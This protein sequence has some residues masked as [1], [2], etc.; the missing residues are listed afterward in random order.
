MRL[1][2][3]S[4][5][6]LAALLALAALAAAPAGAAAPIK[7]STIQLKG[8]HGYS[9]EL[10]EGISGDF[11][12]ETGIYAE[13]GAIGASYEVLGDLEPGIHASFGDLGRADLSFQRR[14]RVVVRPERGCRI[15]FETGIFRGRFSFRGENGYTRVSAT[16]PRGEVIRL[17]NGFCG[18]GAF[19]NGEPFDEEI[20]QVAELAAAARTPGGSTRFAATSLRVAPVT[21]LGAAVREAVGQ[22]QITRGATAIRG[23][24]FEIGAGK[25]PRRARV[26]GF[27]PFDGSAG[28]RNP[29]RAAPTW[30]GSLRVSLPGLPD[31]PLAGAGFRSRLCPRLFLTAICRLRLPPRGRTAGRLAALRRDLAQIRGSQ[32]QD[33]GEDR[34]SWS[35]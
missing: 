17:P 33:L 23:G 4:L 29:R 7:V 26:R 18:F 10:L 24:R 21:I 2:F 31:A 27:G 12:A 1:A 30:R 28:Y 35:R 11:P 34:L 5:R 9:V 15:V 13:R 3:S 14:K 6:A 16:R 19:L 25:P 20:F 32:S 8:T 22:M